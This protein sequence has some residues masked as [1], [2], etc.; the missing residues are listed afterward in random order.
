MWLADIMGMCIG[1]PGIP[2]IGEPG[3]ACMLWACS[4][5]P[6]R[7]GAPRNEMLWEY[8]QAAPREQRPLHHRRVSRVPRILCKNSTPT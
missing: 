7:P 2:I 5:A 3:M 8:L 1:E 6:S 4:A